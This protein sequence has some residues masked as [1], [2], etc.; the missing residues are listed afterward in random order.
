MKLV[1]NPLRSSRCIGGLVLLA[2]PAL[3]AGQEA[4][5]GGPSGRSCAESAC[6]TAQSLR[7]VLVGRVVDPDGVP[8]AGA[9]VV[10]SAGGQALTDARGDYRLE[11]E[12]PLDAESVQVTASGRT[13]S[14][15]L[16][17]SARVAITASRTTRA[18]TLALQPGGCCQPSWVPTFGERPG[19]TGPGG[20][21][22]FALTAFDDG[23]GP[24]LYVA[25]GFQ[26]AGGV[27]ASEIAKWNGSSWSALGSGTQTGRTVFALAVYDDGSGPALYAGGNFTTA[28]GAAASRVAKWNGSSWSALGSGL[29]N[30]VRVLA[31]FDDG[32]GPALYAGGDFTTAGGTAANRIARWN[33]SSWSAL[34]SGLDG[35][36]RALA[37]YDDGSGPALYAGG[38]FATAGGLPASRIAK[39]NGSSWSALGSGMSGGSVSGPAVDSLAAYDDGGGPL[40]YAGGDFTSAGGVAANHIASWDGSGW[41][42][43]GSGLGG[44]SSPSANALMVFDDGGGPVLQV[45]G[46]FTTAGGGPA[47]HTAKWDGSSWSALAGSV[48]PDGSVRAI[49]AFDDGS[50]P[51]LFWGGSLKHAAGQAVNNVAKWDGSSW[52]PLGSGLDDFVVDALTVFD[53]GDGPALYAGGDFTQ[54]SGVAAKDIA[55]WD[56]SSWAALG[57]GF[58]FRVLAL[59]VFDDGGGAALYAGGEFTTAGGASAG[60]IAK[61]DGSSWS[62][63]GT[64]MGLSNT[65]VSALV[66][67]DDGGGPALYAGGLFSSAG[68][69][70]A[71]NVARWDGSSW[72]ALGSG[73][74]AR[75]NALAVLDDGGGRAL[76]AGGDFTSAGGLPASCIAKWDGSSW[77]ALGGGTNFR[78]NAL[79]VLDDGSGPALYAGGDFTSAGGVAANRIARWD[80][81]FWSALGS[82]TNERVFALAVHDDGGGP[83][84]YAGGFFTSAGG[85]VANRIARW[86]GSSWSALGGGMNGFVGALQV[87][88]DGSSPAL[89]AG[90]DFAA[91]LDSRDGFIAKWGCL[92]TAPPTLSCPSGL[93][94]RDGRDDPPGEI[95]NFTVTATDGCDAAPSVVCVP[96]SGSFFPRGTTTVTCTATDASGNQAT[97]S[98]PV[99]VA[100]PPRA[101]VH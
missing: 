100:L 53:D 48:G 93:V 75:V 78:V 60:K 47:M 2:M 10:T 74:N 67:F 97:C 69:G 72:S 34:A 62:T 19:V 9:V 90:G 54:A 27:A 92:D 87:F 7:V 36:V 31:V 94:V 45:G 56:G 59:R 11:V 5:R 98:F 33:G 42:A 16:V 37:A 25:G 95:V 38:S 73:T 23:S 21:N 28:G 64:G 13:A 91:S 49:E 8:R 17:A 76:Y 20:G 80:G 84:L 41:S 58:N 83:A 55:K 15:S 99:V 89:F 52:S 66:V 44:V 82:G 6:A 3:V 85:V 35:A 22:V 86:D 68:G 29:D 18:G 24:A 51:A 79:A 96:P 65:S 101:R 70:A 14:G 39:W 81:S 40:L 32:S 26:T 61:W 50:G 1:T 88:D 57:S 77:S 12:V 71:N 30:T 63:L 46:F 43:L 4:R